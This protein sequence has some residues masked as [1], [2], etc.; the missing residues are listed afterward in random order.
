MNREQRRKLNKRYKVNYS[1]DEWRMIELYTQIRS[2]DLDVHDLS[3]LAPEMRQKIHIDN[4]NLVPEG[5]EVKLNAEEI[6]SRPVEMQEAYREWVKANADKVF[7]VTREEAEASMVC[8][9]ED[10]ED[11]KKQREEK[12][13]ANVDH[14]VWLFDIYNDLLFLSAKDQT[15]KNLIFI[16][17]ENSEKNA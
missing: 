3:G 1:A 11:I 6:L 7:H 10:V 5:T 15:W 14:L 4:E 13:E 8:L 2:G 16:E 17:Q 9:K 12:G